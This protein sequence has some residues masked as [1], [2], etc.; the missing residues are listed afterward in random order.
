MYFP[1][2]MDIGGKQVIVIG[3]GTVALRKCELFVRFGADVTVIA[4][5]FCDEL[6][7]LSGVRIL[8]QSCDLAQLDGAFAVIAAT[9]DR[10]VNRAVSDYCQARRIPVNVVDDPELCSFIVPS[11]VQRGDLTFA[12][13][14]GGKSPALAAK[15]RRELERCYEPEY[16]ERLALLGE[17]RTKVLASRMAPSARRSLLVRAAELEPADLRSLL[18]T[19]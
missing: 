5:E 17:L 18:Q 15:I 11:T 10:E 7:Q 8:R 3:G 6:E 1:F 19:V 16:A 9:D 2:M 4:P 12:I 13:S 14:T